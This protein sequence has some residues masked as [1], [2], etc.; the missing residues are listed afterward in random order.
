MQFFVNDKYV[1]NKNSQKL[2]VD[3]FI[4]TRI[5]RNG[6]M[7]FPADIINEKIDFIMIGDD[8]TNLMPDGTDA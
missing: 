5:I 7:Y 8:N 3:D 2:N 6:L 1:N 4:T